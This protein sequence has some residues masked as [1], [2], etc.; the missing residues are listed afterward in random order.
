MDRE[1]LV[2]KLLIAINDEEKVALCLT[3]NE[4]DRLIDALQ[5]LISSDG[6]Y[7]NFKL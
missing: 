7:I 1:I 2:Q 5:P 6:W 4:L 3:R